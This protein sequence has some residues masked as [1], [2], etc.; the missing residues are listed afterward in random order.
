MEKKM[1]KLVKTIDFFGKSKERRVCSAYRSSIST[2]PMEE[3]ILHDREY[4]Y[5]ST[6]VVGF[7]I[8][9]SIGNN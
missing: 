3:R 4:V 8:S 9:F 5:M 2:T 1:K 6:S 7:C